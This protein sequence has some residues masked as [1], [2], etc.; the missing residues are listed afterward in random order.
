MSTNCS[1]PKNDTLR[2]SPHRRSVIFYLGNPIHLAA[3]RQTTS[4]FLPC[5]L[6]L[7]PMQDRKVMSYAPVVFNLF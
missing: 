3:V 5:S 6:L 4:L 1:L 7:C 2:K